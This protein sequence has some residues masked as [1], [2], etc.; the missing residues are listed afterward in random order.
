MSQYKDTLNLPQTA[1][2]MKANLPNREP[3]ILEYWARID[4]YHR[5]RE[6]RKDWPLYVMHDGPP[7]ASGRPHMGTAM[8][9]TIKDIIVKS[10]GFSGYNAPFVPGWDCHGLPI[11]LNVEKNFGKPGHKISEA[12]FRKECRLFAEKQVAIQREDFERLGVLADW[13]NPYLTM[14]YR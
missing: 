2:P 5:L 12:E 3:S 4:L 9:K 8:N 10:R 11:E 14:D 1:F 13:K 6:E 7:Y